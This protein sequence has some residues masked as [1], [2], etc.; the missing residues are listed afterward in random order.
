D[1][2]Q[3]DPGWL[4]GI[5][6][7][8][9]DPEVA[10][11]TGL[12]LPAEL[13]T[14]AQAL[15]ECYGGMSKGLQPRRFQRTT[16]S[17]I[18]MLAAHALGVGANMAFR[19][20][21]LT[22]LGGFDTALDVGTPSGG[23]GDLDLFH[24]VLAAGLTCAYEPTACVWHQHRR[25][26]AGLRTQIENNGRAFGIYLLKIWTQRSAPRQATLRFTYRWLRHYL[27]PQVL[28]S[29]RHTHALPLW[30]TLA[31]LRGA[32]DAPR[33]FRATYAH[34]RRMRQAHKLTSSLG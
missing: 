27:L 31:E 6:Q 9:A 2:V 14:E 11:V 12:V 4:Y 10:A 19:R 24:R 33:A 20:T 26:M 34:D 28:R 22:Q 32:L 29:L 17:V 5:A 15:F 1:D 3:V 8:F 16:M 7:A 25:D 18:D 30:L 23:G 21:T 13:D